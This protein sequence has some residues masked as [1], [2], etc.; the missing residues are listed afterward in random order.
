MHGTQTGVC[1]HR[2][3]AEH[4]APAY[5]IVLDVDREVFPYMV[6]RDRMAE[7]RGVTFVSRHSSEAQARGMVRILQR[8]DR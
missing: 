7:G 5:I 6:L 4:D 2:P 8:I 3:C 1:L